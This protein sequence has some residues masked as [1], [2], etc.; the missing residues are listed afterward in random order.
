MHSPRGFPRW[1]IAGGR[2]E[3]TSPADGLVRPVRLGVR[4]LQ[5][6]HPQLAVGRPGEGEAG[7]EHLVRAARVGGAGQH[8]VHQHGDPAAIHEEADGVAPA[9]GGG[10]V[11]KQPRHQVVSLRHASQRR[12]KPAVPD[13]ACHDASA[14]NAGRTGRKSLF[15]R[16]VISWVNRSSARAYEPQECSPATTLKFL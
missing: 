6:A 8:V 15:E 2:R 1:P 11:C 14:T 7:V 12:Q 10:G 13:A 9:G 4:L 16:C 5:Q 3:Y